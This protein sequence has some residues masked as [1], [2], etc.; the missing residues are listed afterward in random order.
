MHPMFSATGP[1]LSS[2]DLNAD[3]R[4][5]ANQTRNM[6]NEMLSAQR[7]ESH[8]GPTVIHYYHDYNRPWWNRSCNP[9]WSP[10]FVQPVYIFP[11]QSRSYNDN[12]GNNNNVL[13]GIAAAIVG[14]VAAFFVGSGISALEDSTDALED[15]HIQHQ[16]FKDYASQRSQPEEQQKIQQALYAA[17]LKERICR[18]IKSS[19]VSDLVFR[20]GVLAGA[21]FA[22]LGAVCTH[23][24][25]IT[26]GIVT[27]CVFG[28]AMIFKA[29]L[30]S[31]KHNFRDAAELKQVVE[32]M[33]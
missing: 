14:G 21:T 19:A 6:A 5:F 11:S 18:R 8:S 16:K 15:T 30:G 20:V 27:G 12:R 25:W 22:F 26:A 29:G 31:D 23:P 9:F 28:L 7:G 24:A 17:S 33:G 32:N 10:F 3:L 4:S 13:I 2:A 1:N